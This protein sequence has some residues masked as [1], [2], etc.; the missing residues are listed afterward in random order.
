VQ[1]RERQVVVE[2]VGM[3][4]ELGADGLEPA[5]AEAWHVAKDDRARLR[6]VIDQVASL[7][8]A[9]AAALHA[10]VCPPDPATLAG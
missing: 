1:A 2:L 5:H 4:A 3:L 6:V 9:A 8:D 10:G 7:T